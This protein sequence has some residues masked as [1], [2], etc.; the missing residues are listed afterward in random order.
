[1]H[2]L[3]VCLLAVQ[4]WFINWNGGSGK[5]WR[6]R[7]N[8]RDQVSTGEFPGG[9]GEQVHGRQPLQVWRGTAWKHGGT[10]RQTGGMLAV[11]TIGA[12]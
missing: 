3:A 2:F 1:M 7:G 10:V 8:P 11:D 4:S 5:R 6:A 12:Q 9:G